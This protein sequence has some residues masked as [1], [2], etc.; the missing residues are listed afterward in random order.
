[1]VDEKTCTLDLRLEHVI[2]LLQAWIYRLDRLNLTRSACGERVRCVY[3]QITHLVISLSL[4]HVV[5]TCTIISRL[6][7]TRAIRYNIV[8]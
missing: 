8:I 5:V 2:L 1:M 4:S 6:V 7:S 3:G